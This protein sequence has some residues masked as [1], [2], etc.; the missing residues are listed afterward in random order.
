[1]FIILS[2]NDTDCRKQFIALR[3]CKTVTNA[4]W[5]VD[6]SWWHVTTVRYV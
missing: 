3:Q 5:W 4:T 1:M 2:K 6:I